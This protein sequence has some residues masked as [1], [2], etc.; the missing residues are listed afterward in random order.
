VQ[1]VYQTDPHIPTQHPGLLE[2]HHQTILRIFAAILD[3]HPGKHK[4]T[5]QLEKFILQGAKSIMQQRPELRGVLE[6]AVAGWS[7]IGVA[8]RFL[9]RLDGATV[10]VPSM[11]PMPST[12]VGA[13]LSSS[14]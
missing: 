4:I 6:S 10:V 7:D 2:P 13:A 1:C 12:L 9:G 3:S 5:P 14:S 8:E 11:V